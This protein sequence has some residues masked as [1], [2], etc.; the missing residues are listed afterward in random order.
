MFTKNINMSRGQRILACDGKCS[1]AWGLC[2]RPRIDLDKDEPDDYVFLSDEEA[3]DAPAN[4]GTYEGGF[5][6]PEGPHAMNKWCTRQCERSVIVTPGE[7]IRL[8][9]WSI[10][11]YNQPWKHKQAST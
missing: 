10:R 3:E 9:D 6:K 8:E 1:K 2:M 7:S 11:R 5:G 4:P